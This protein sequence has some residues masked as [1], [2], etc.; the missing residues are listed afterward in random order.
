ML[1]MNWHSLYN[2]KRSEKHPWRSVT[3]NE[4]AGRS[5]I[6]QSITN[7]LA[8]YI[9]FRDITKD[10]ISMSLRNLLKFQANFDEIIS[11]CSSYL[12]HCYASYPCITEHMFKCV[13]FYV[14]P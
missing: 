1:C 2:L 14:L 10:F 8:I 11:L 3:V 7:I 13:L 9:F 12:V 6:V 4:I 5:Q